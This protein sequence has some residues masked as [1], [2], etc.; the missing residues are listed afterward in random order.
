MWKSSKASV[1]ISL[2]HLKVIGSELSQRGRSDL[3]A[4]ASKGPFVQRLETLDILVS[5]TKNG[6]L[7]SLP[8]AR[9]QTLNTAPARV[10]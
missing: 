10:A 2:S 4:T 6:Q 8:L 1:P 7:S 5:T 3:T 9:L